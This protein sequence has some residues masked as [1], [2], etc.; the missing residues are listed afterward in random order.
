M[1][2]PPAALLLL[3]L[4]TL[5]RGSRSSAGDRYPPAHFRRGGTGMSHRQVATHVGDVGALRAFSD[6]GGVPTATY[7]GMNPNGSKLGITIRGASSANRWRPSAD[8]S[9]L[10]TSCR[11][12][13]VAVAFTASSRPS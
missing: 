10:P 12:C 5:G 2:L 8:G 9:R 11:R 6:A 3:S 4:L 1:E 7:E 13:H